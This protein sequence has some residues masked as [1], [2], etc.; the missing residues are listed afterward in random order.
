MNMQHCKAAAGILSIGMEDRMRVAAEL[1]VAGVAFQRSGT[2]WDVISHDGDHIG[3]LSTHVV[4]QAS[5]ALKLV[6]LES[7][8]VTDLKA[9]EEQSVTFGHFH[10]RPDELD[11]IMDRRSRRFS[12]VC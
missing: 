6:G 3:E 11:A 9:G 4:C 12:T 5:R 8:S 1:L 2:R 10:P 7:T